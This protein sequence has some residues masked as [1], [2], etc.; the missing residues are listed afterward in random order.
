MINNYTAVGR[1]TADAELKFLGSGTAV[2][3]FSLCINDSYKKDGNWVDRPYFFNCVVWG[4]YAEAMSPHLTKGRLIGIEGKLTHNPW[5]DGNGSR[6]NDCSI[7]VASIH[8]F[9]KPGSGNSG[10]GKPE[11]HAE[12]PPKN[13]GGTGERPYEDDIPF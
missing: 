1:L 2:A 10:N 8:L 11:N 3:K 5:V 7:V 4:K 13:E 6:H 12:P 9:P